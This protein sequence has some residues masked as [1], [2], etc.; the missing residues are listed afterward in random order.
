V[1]GVMNVFYNG[2]LL[3]YHPIGGKKLRELLKDRL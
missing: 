1:Y 2:E 3:T